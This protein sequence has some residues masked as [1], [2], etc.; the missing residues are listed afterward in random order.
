MNNRERYGCC[1]RTMQRKE[2]IVFCFGSITCLCP[3]PF[4]SWFLRL[5]P[6]YTDNFCQIQF[7]HDKATILLLY[8]SNHWPQI[9]FLKIITKSL[10]L[11]VF[12]DVAGL[13]LRGDNTLAWDP[14]LTVTVDICFVWPNLWKDEKLEHNDLDGR[15]NSLL[16]SPDSPG[17]EHFT[18]SRSQITIMNQKKTF[19]CWIIYHNHSGSPLLMNTRKACNILLWLASLSVVNVLFPLLSESITNQGL[20]WDSTTCYPHSGSERQEL[21]FRMLSNW[22]EWK[23]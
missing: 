23:F 18:I 9:F 2:W 1:Y 4:W 13:C 15:S 21:M 16:I 17:W 12:W 8:F 20:V 5:Q 19:S 22:L 6:H 3:C 10:L 7:H 11:R 14:A